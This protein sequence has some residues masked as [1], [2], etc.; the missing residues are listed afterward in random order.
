MAVLCLEVVVAEDDLRL[1][2]VDGEVVV[3]NLVQARGTEAGRVGGTEA[4]I[5]R[6]IHQDGFR[7]QLIA[8]GLVARVAQADG[9]RHGVQQFVLMLGVGRQ[10][11]GVLVDVARGGRQ[12]V[13]APVGTDDGRTALQQTEHGLQV[14]LHRALLLGLHVVARGIVLGVYGILLA[15]AEAV[16]GEVGL[17]RVAVG[18]LIDTAQIPAE[19]LVAHL[20]VGASRDVLTRVGTVGDLVTVVQSGIE[21]QMLVGSVG[22]LLSHDA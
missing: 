19:A 16:D 6:G 18:E 10:R 17:Q 14:S 7:S 8:K 13:F 2:A 1:V 15:I 12:I 4:E 9:G 3:V 11:I 21:G 22:E 5:A 20:V